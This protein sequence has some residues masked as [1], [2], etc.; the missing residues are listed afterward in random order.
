MTSLFGRTMDHKLLLHNTDSLA[1]LLV[2]TSVFTGADGVG[3]EL[4]EHAE[5]GRFVLL[6][7]SPTAEYLARVSYYLL[8]EELPDLALDSVRFWET[9][10]CCAIYREGM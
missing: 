2:Q 8:R 10:N 1:A 6:T 7:H 3:G 4:W 9:P 5:F